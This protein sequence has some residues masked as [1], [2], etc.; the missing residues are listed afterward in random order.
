[1]TYRHI[2]GR[3]DIRAWQQ[4]GRNNRW[5]ATISDASS[6]VILA[7]GAGMSRDA[8]IADAR[9]KLLPEPEEIVRDLPTARYWA[10]LAVGVTVIGWCA[11]I[12]LHWAV[13]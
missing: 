5:C 7:T 8:A 4:P 10:A 6:K 9:G 2:A 13:S 3:H 11:Y 1:M 12:A